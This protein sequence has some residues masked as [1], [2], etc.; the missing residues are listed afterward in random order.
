MVVKSSIK[1]SA[2]LILIGTLWYPVLGQRTSAQGVDDQR[3]VRAKEV[4][5]GRRR[6]KT[7]PKRD[8]IYTTNKPFPL[9]APPKN[10]TYV[11]VGFTLWRIRVANEVQ[12]KDPKVQKE[13]MSWD[14]QDHEVVVTRMSDVNPIP[15]QELIQL[16][17]EYLP[18]GGEV[19]VNRARYLYVI[20][21]EQFADGKLR[22]ARLIFPTLK[23][24][25]G[26]NRLLPGKTVTLPDP[27]RP[28]IISRAVSQGRQT[29]EAYTIILSPVSLHS[30]LPQPL[31]NKAME[32]SEELMATWEKR[33]RSVEVR[34]DLRNGVGQSRTERE[35]DSS[36]D[37][38]ENRGTKD[39]A[40]DLTQGD[41]PPQTVFRSV[42][43][44]SAAVLFTVR[45]PFAESLT[46]PA[47]QNVPY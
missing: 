35:I 2:L 20:N 28:F 19:E 5:K 31:S 4:L 24:Y 44:K 34:A 39:S 18:S 40:E 45:V 1:F 22:N 33:W 21:R 8:E 41:A 11:T 14:E 27:E 37:V 10:M 43:K 47:G 25:E 42:V 32:L 3:D 29:S 13:R 15:N 46:K 30:E 6:G 12:S 26:D 17:I 38:E 23:T 16:T 7:V 36:G 9:G